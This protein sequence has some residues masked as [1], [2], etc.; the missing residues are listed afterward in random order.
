MGCLV[1]T[2]LAKGLADRTACNTVLNPEVPD[3]LVRAG[4]GPAIL[5]HGMGE[6]GRIEIQA[7][8]LFPGIIDPGSKMLG[9]KLIPGDLHAIG[10]GDV[11]KRQRPH[12]R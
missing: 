11:Y 2:S 1:Y 3:A 4:Q 8:P 6:V 12:S 9:P 5:E 10:Q 7:D